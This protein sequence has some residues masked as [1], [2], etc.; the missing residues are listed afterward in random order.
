MGAFIV[1]FA[2][3]LVSRLLRA[4]LRSGAFYFFVILNKAC[5]LSKNKM[6]SPFTSGS[7]L[8]A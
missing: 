1:Q 3:Q 4:S 8:A 2:A 6:H 7:L 5:T